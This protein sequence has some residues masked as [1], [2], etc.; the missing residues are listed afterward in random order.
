MIYIASPYSDP[1]KKKM[2][3]RF[4][5]VCRYAGA[6][7]KKGE[8]VFSPIAHCHPIAE[9]FDLPRTWEFWKKVDVGYLRLASELRVLELDG[10]KESTGVAQEVYIAGTLG[11]P[12]HFIPAPKPAA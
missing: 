2:Q 11:I 6:C 10:W 5:A 7:L 3:E 9:R 8:I 12:I 4:E 1:D